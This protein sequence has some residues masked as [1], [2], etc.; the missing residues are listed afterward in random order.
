MYASILESSCNVGSIPFR[1]QDDPVMYVL[2]K[3]VEQE[4][5]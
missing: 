2:C 1:L 4:L 3:R 5:M